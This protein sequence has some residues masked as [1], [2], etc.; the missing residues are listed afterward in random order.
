MMMNIDNLL[1]Y[2]PCR[3]KR[4]TLSRAATNKCA[5]I[6]ANPPRRLMKKQA[7]AGSRI[8]IRLRRGPACGQSQGSEILD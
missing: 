4:G 7:R 2:D 3:M 5:I 1:F 6:A 8:E